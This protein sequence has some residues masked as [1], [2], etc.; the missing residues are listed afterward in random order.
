MTEYWQLNKSQENHID[1]FVDKFKPGWTIHKKFATKG[2]DG[3]R[4][5]VSRS[6]ITRRGSTPT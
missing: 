5:D 2:A 6:P 4:Q 3:L 1:S